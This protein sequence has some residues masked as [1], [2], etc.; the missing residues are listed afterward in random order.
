MMVCRRLFEQKIKQAFTRWSYGPFRKDR[1]PTGSI[2]YLIL[3]QDAGP[4]TEAA[5]RSQSPINLIQ[6]I[7]RAQCR[8]VG[9][10]LYSHPV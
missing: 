6:C 4:Q 1:P 5:A 7:D 10:L 3:V 8:R 2:A 9:Y